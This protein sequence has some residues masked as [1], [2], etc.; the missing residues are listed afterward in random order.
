MSAGT[1]GVDSGGEHEY[2]VVVETVAHQDGASVEVGHAQGFSGVSADGHGA[3][4]AGDASLC[5]GIER[6]AA[7]ASERVA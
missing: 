6:Y 7:D 4:S 3:A 5:V 1:H 2:A